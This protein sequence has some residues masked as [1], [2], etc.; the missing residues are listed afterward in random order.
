MKSRIIEFRAQLR[1]FERAVN[2][3]N[4]SECC[5]GVTL[6][7]CHTILEVEKHG[8]L[9]SN[10]LAEHLGLDKSTISR[11]LDKLAKKDAISRVIPAENR[12]SNL[13]SL[14]EKGKGIADMINAGNNHYYEQALAQFNNQDREQF[15]E[16]FSQFVAEMEQLNDQKQCSKG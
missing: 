4:A 1:R 3:Q 7:E 15:M 16:L 11:T 9:T 8:M 10:Q 6:A 13:I 14:T 2:F 12:R 5:C